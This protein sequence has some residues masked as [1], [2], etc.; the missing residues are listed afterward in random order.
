MQQA[1]ILIQIGTAFEV[2]EALAAET[3]H[4]FHWFFARALNDKLRV[5]QRYH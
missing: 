4:Q 3:K 2:L 5:F 1:P